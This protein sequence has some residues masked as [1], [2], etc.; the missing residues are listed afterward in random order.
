[1]GTTAQGAK[2]IST[3]SGRA[4]FFREVDPSSMRIEDIAHSLG[5]QCRF[6]GHCNRFYSV[7]EHSVLLSEIVPPE[8]AYI[9]LMHDATEA[10]V[11]DV[12]RPLKDELP[13]YQVVE[14]R[15]WKAMAP[16]FDLP[17]VLPR[18]I[19]VADMAMLKREVE[20]M[21]PAHVALMLDLPG[22]PAAI[23]E[24]FHW[25][26]EHAAMRFMERYHELKPH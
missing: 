18:E 23:E 6:T 12:A 15:V 14:A 17:L 20:C 7:A 9:G 4:F 21:F 10:Y 24:F 5:M 3:V 19:K 26:P 16:H 22:H 2:Y 1:M 11:G 25:T 13:D 8:L